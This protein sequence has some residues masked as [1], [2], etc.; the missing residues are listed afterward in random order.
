MLEHRFPFLDKVGQW[1]KFDAN[2]GGTLVEKCCHYFD[3]MNLFADARPV[4]VFANGNQSVNFKDFERDGKSADCL[5]QANVL[6]DYANGVMLI[7]S[8]FARVSMTVGNGQRT[9]NSKRSS[10]DVP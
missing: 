1:N 7:A 6:V 10:R 9:P 8:G 4:R 5:D 3:L 2:T